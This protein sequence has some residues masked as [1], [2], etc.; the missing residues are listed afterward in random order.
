MLLLRNELFLVVDIPGGIGQCAAR[1]GGEDIRVL[2]T[3]VHFCRQHAGKR[4]RK[5]AYFN[6]FFLTEDVMDQQKLLPHCY[7]N[8]NK[9]KFLLF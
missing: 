5:H 6:I 2:D 7:L 1:G 3:L 8:R 4:F 9:K